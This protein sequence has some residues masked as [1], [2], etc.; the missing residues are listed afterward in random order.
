MVILRKSRRKL[1]INSDTAIRRHRPM[2]QILLFMGLLL[3]LGLV[4]MFAIGPHRANVLNFGQGT[5]YSDSYFFNKQ[6]VSVIMSTIAFAAC[7]I[8]PY[9]LFTKSYAK[10]IFLIGLAACFLLVIFGAVLNLPIARETNGAYR[11]FFLGPF[12]SFQPA[13]LLKFGLL[14]FVGGFLG[15]RVKQGKI[16][17]TQE[18]IVPLSVI[19]GASLFVVVFLQKDLGTGVSLMAIVLAMLVVSGMK[20][21]LLGK[22]VG[23][24]ALAGVVMIVSAPHRL[25]RVMTFTQGDNT[26]TIEQDG[27]SYHIQQARI[28][29]GSGGLFGLGIGGSVQATGYLPEAIN[30]SIFAIMG[31]T[32]GFVGLLVIMGLFTALLLAL[33][34]V[35]SR[36]PDMGLRL[37][38]AGVF[39]WVAAHVVL[40]IAAMTGIAP[41]TGIPLPLLSYGGT[42]MMFVAAALGLA[43]QLSGYTSHKPLE[44]GE[45][46]DK[47]SGSRRRVGRTR[48]AGRS[49]F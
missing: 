2:Y 36:L 5:E 48:Y 24:L 7:A 39:G 12:G 20:F 4:V 14:L 10:H 45:G 18:T 8:I 21:D 3:L 13:E 17:D 26:E 19:V 25:E 30:D 23:V 9:R 28:A 11:W 6:L 49:G 1:S 15:R 44:E 42:S 35:A 38:V 37:V 22:I 46:N 34:R 47:N 27:N 16:N 29:I 41:L 43:F 40:N 31:E 32:L 33:L